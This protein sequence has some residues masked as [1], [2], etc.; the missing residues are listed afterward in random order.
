MGSNRKKEAYR[1][2]SEDSH[3]DREYGKDTRTEVGNEVTMSQSQVKKKL[4]DK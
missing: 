3:H 1:P 2:H 4:S